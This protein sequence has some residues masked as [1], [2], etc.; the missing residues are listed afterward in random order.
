M[1]IDEGFKDSLTVTTKHEE[2]G[3]SIW[4]EYNPPDKLGI[5]GDNVAVDLDLCIGDGA[6]L[7]VCPEDVYE[8]VDFGGNDKALPVRQEDCIEC[9][10]C[11]DDCP[12]GAIKIFE[13]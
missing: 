3:Y 10:A 5:H 12:E 9:L 1:P 8:L 4:G 11:E 13:A 6:C 2:H 7:D